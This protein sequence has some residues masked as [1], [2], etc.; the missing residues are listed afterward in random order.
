MRNDETE[1]RAAAWP[2]WAP[3][4]SRSSIHFAEPD[5]VASGDRKTLVAHLAEILLLFGIGLGLA[6][7]LAWSAVMAWILLQLALRA[8]Q[9]IL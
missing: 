3:Q 8:A 5:A 9:S 2:Y 4:R 7:T 1:A 6:G